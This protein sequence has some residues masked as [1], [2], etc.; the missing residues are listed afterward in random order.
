MN[1]KLNN[2][3]VEGYEQLIKFSLCNYFQNFHVLRNVYKPKY[4]NLWIDR[5]T[6]DYIHFEANVKNFDS[7]DFKIK[8]TTYLAVTAKQHLN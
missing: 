5:L 3:I 1:K 6:E 8:W 7:V 2:T 4:D